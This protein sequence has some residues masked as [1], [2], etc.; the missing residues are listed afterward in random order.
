MENTT[1]RRLPRQKITEIKMTLFE[2]RRECARRLEKVATTF[3]DLVGKRYP[4]LRDVEKMSLDHLR[5][6]P[7]TGTAFEPVVSKLNQLGHR[8]RPTIGAVMERLS[9][10][11]SDVEFILGDLTQGPTISAKDMAGHL[12]WLA[13]PSFADRLYFARKYVLEILGG[14]ESTQQEV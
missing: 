6:L 4:S 9:L 1:R 5:A 2:Q 12:R 3:D 7:S 13:R 8:V 10:T 11:K 14:A